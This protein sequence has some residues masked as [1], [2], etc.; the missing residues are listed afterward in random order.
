LS[1]LGSE[2]HVIGKRMEVTA[3]RANGNEFPVEISIT[4]VGRDAPAIFTAFVR[5]VTEPKR[6]A[7]ELVRSNA[8]LRTLAGVSDAFAMVT[9]THQPLLEKIAEVMAELVGDSCLVTLVSDDGKRMVDVASAHRDPAHAL[10]GKIYLT[11]IGASRTTVVRTG[12]PVRADLLPSTMVAQAEDPLVPS[13]ACRD[14]HGFVVIPI[15]ARQA[16]IGT[17]SLVRAQPG[18]SFSDEEVTLLQDLADRAGLAIENARLYAQLEQRVQERTVKLEAANKELGAF[19]YSVAHDLRAPLRAMSGYSHLLLEDHAAR[20]GPEGMDCVTE[21]RGA[22]N[23]MNQIIEGLLQLANASRTEP[24]RERV[25]MSELARV[26]FARLAAAQSER[27]VEIVVAPGLV[28]HADPRLLEI[29]LT[30]LLGN[31]W[32]FTG[33]RARARI[34]LA[35]TGADDQPRTYF[36]RDNGAGF[37]AAYAEKLFG[38]FQRLHSRHDFEGTGI[39][40]ATVQRIIQSHGGR[41][42][43]EG[44]EDRGATFYFTL[45]AV[46][47]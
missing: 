47:N 18:R 5:D 14:D 31:A 9:T 6:V 38:A 24:R 7:A 40:L 33:K 21:I 3:L 34:E 2:E 20:L 41:I 13:A 43:A 46:K 22:A 1:R 4:R 29:A 19:S 35:G 8:R 17:L 42:W 15:R 44:A 26:V 23:Q 32:K 45:E 10:H 30:N 12:Q 25:D 11:G 37:G 28:V 27:A 16:V 39:G 36:V